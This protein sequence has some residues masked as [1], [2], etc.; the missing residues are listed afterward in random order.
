M[1]QLRMFSDS[2]LL[3][4]HRHGTNSTPQVSHGLVHAR[5]A[6]PGGVPAGDDAGL[7]TSGVH[8]HVIS[9][10]QH[11]HAV[12]DGPAEKD[13]VAVPVPGN[14][15]H[16]VNQGRQV[17]ERDLDVLLTHGPVRVPV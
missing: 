5:P 11:T 15:R 10:L 3:V 4:S 6:Q 7:A 13:L 16:L 14:R 2:Q 9:T 8:G 17:L 12:E 1:V